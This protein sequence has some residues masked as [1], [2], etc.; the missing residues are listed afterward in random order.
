MK[1]ETFF[2]K[3]DILAE[4]PGG[5]GKL[6]ELI[7]HW[8][9]RGK[10]V[11]SDP[12]PTPAAK[13]FPGFASVAVDAGADGLPPH[14][15]RVPLGKAGEWRG[16][17]TPSKA[18]A[19][20]WDGDVPWVSPKDMKSLR[21]SD[22]QDHISEAA[23]A[24]S[25]VTEIPAGSI[26]MVVRGMILARAFPVAVTTRAVTINQDMKA[27]TPRE[28]GVA[29][30][31]LLALRASEVEVLSA[32]ERSSHGT[33][34]LGTSFLNA[35]TIPI[36]PLGEMKRIVAKVDELMSL[37]DR[38][39]AQQQERETR[40]ATLAQAALARF[41]EAPTRANLN[42]LFHDSYT[43]DPA[44]LS[45]AVLSLG[46]LGLLI[47]GG[48]PER[49]PTRKLKKLSAKIGSGSTPSGGR[50]SYKVSGVP[51][52]RSMNVHFG[53]FVRT[54]LAFLDDDQAARMASAT[55]QADDV[56]LNITGASIGR[57]CVAPADVAGARVNQHVC[58]VRPLPAILPQFLELFLASP[59]VQNRIVDIQV[60]ATREALTKA[61]IEQFDVPLPSLAEQ[62]QTVQRVGYLMEL[63]HGLVREAGDAHDAGEGLTRALVS[64]IGPS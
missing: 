20:F 31:L 36:P 59:M 6:R 30:F 50:D 21:I 57:V 49:W 55:V 42:F 10:L 29:E 28:K 18:N 62:E 26:L 46:V 47:P 5:V 19:A 22:A 56:L 8:A 23:V 16:G 9:V 37:C 34:K 4:A 45:G 27:L 13:S 63:V 17:G 41:A 39:E 3:F 60:G 54:G 43:L 64:S 61:M 14:W 24:A 44:D 25:S 11:P 1:L 51:L 38:L 48:K 7:L 15:L 12:R 52:I 32:V 58:I 2:E 53:G 35:F 40:R 33:C